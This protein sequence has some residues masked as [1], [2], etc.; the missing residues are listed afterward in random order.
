MRP[1]PEYRTRQPGR[2]ITVRY[3]RT[4]AGEGHLAAV[5]VPGENEVG[6]IGHCCIEYPSIWRVRDSNIQLCGWVSVVKS[7]PCVSLHV[8]VVGA[9]E[10]DDEFIAR[11]QGHGFFDNTMP[12]PIFGI[13][14][15]YSTV[16][17]VLKRFWR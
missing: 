9:G 14:I 5:C 16:I 8:C 12:F 4:V 3:E 1:Q 15:L 17:D 13:F 7:W 6:A 2:Q 10:I 11:R